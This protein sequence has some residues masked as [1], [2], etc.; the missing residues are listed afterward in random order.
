MPTGTLIIQNEIKKIAKSGGTLALYVPSKAKEYFAQGDVVNVA[1]KIVDNQ[2]IMTVEKKL[3]NFDISDIRSLAKK[4]DFTVKFDK[5]LAGVSVFYATRRDG[6]SLSYTQSKQEKIAPGYVALSR[7]L[8]VLNPESYRDVNNIAKELNKRFDV[9][10]ERE[11]DL[12]TINI[13]KEPER[14]KLELDQ[15]IKMITNSGRK[16]GLALVIRFNNKKNKLEEV[17]SALDQLRQLEIKP[18]A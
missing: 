11:G 8:E 5:E 15:A 2:I 16:V 1:V 14:Y 6:I 4:Y 3:Y 7:K 10:L 17:N 12:D 13:L 18:T 9:I